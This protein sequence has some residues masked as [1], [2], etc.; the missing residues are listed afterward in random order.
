LSL[1]LADKDARQAVLAAARLPSDCGELVLKYI[2]FFSPPERFLT[3]SRAAKLIT[4]C[5]DM[6][7]NGVDFDR[8]RI[9]APSHIWAKALESMQSAEL[10]RPLKNH[11]YLLRIV[12]GELAQK[13][14]K[15]QS[16]TH[17][18]RRSEARVNSP[19]M[20][21]VGDVLD[22]A[23][24]PHDSTSSATKDPFKELSPEARKQALKEAEETLLADG[25]HQAF[26]G[27]PLIEQ[28]AREL[29]IDK[30]EA[31]HAE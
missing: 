27:Q 11:H 22:G 4:E 16:D 1:F 5:S 28:K 9:Q 23:M 10:R 25:F 30:Q 18:S 19:A 17:Q 20:Q 6:I 31:S 14:D 2:G 26:L 7:L 13:W 8:A 21:S 12:Q 3:S 24:N 29:F 15:Q